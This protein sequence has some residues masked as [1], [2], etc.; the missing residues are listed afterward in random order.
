MGEAAL[1]GSAGDWRA[2][3]EVKFTKF[4][5]FRE[6][7]EAGWRRLFRAKGPNGRTF[8]RVRAGART[9]GAIGEEIGV[10]ESRVDAGHA[11]DHAARAWR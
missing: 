2:D 3:E 5:E 7:R 8:T 10:S 4:T 9:P 1:L 11:I 6:N